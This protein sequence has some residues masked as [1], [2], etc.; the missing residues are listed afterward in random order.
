MG[1]GGWAPRFEVKGGLGKVGPWK[2]PW[3]QQERKSGDGTCF[4]EETD[5][6]SDPG[7]IVLSPREPDLAESPGMLFKPIL[8][9]FHSQTLIEHLLGVRVYASCPREAL[10][11]AGEPGLCKISQ[12]YRA[13]QS[14]QTR[15]HSGTVREAGQAC[16]SAG[17]A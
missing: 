17:F 6:S 3:K 12:H 4:E 5:L 16:P 7:W 14:G 9:F 1:P 11:L 15:P 2:V 13:V 10:R 8:P